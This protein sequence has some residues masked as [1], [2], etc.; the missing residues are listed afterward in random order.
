MRNV[1]TR[2]LRSVRMFHK[3]NVGRNPDTHVPRFHDMNVSRFLGNN[4]VRFLSRLAIR[5]KPDFFKFHC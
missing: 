3:R 5:Y 2:R 4:A 1:G